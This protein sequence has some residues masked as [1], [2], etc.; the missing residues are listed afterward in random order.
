MTKDAALTQTAASLVERVKD[1]GYSVLYEKLS[2]VRKLDHQNQ[3]P[4]FVYVSDLTVLNHP[5]LSELFQSGYPAK[6]VF[7]FTCALPCAL[8]TMPA[9]AMM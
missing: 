5:H 7:I 4:L 2:D 1:L 3:T 6:T 8:P 9:F